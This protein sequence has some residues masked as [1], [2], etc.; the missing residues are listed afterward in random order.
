[1]KNIPYYISFAL[2]WSFRW[3]FSIPLK[4]IGKLDLLFNSNGRAVPVSLENVLVILE[5][6][7]DLLP[8]KIWYRHGH[9]FVGDN[10]E[11]SLLDGALPFPIWS[12]F[13]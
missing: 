5:V 11:I 2:R 10:G 9:Y 3:S 4:G 8:L 13:Y 7:C 12:G 6:R 1:M